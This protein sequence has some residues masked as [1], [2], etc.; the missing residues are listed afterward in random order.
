MLKTFKGLKGQD[1]K[2]VGVF[3]NCGC[4]VFAHEKNENQFIAILNTDTVLATHFIYEKTKHLTD[5]L[6][7]I[8]KMFRSSFLYRLFFCSFLL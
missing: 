2:P 8:Y 1:P 7:N 4:Q 3:M 5:L 6:Q